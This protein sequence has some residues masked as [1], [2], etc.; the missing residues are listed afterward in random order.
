M[1][2]YHSLRLALSTRRGRHRYLRAALAQKMLE[3]ALHAAILNTPLRT[4]VFYLVAS[5]KAGMPTFAHLEN[6]SIVLF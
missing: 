2:T 1:A 6:H 5:Q 3:A 4:A